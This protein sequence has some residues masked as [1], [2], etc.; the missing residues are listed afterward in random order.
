[1]SIEQSLNGTASGDP[2]DYYY[3]IPDYPET[4]NEGTVAGRVVDGLG[5]RYYWA[6]ENLAVTDL[7]FLHGKDSRSIAEVIDHVL[8]LSVMIVDSIA[9]RPNIRQDWSEIGVSEKR[10]K[11]LDYIRDAAEM[12]KSNKSGMDEYKVIFE[13]PKGTFE[14]PFWNILNGPISDAIYHVG[15]IV[16]LRRLSGNPINPGVRVFLGRTD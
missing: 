1:M 5:F 15:Q 10:T 14:Y 11:A 2:S 16:T 7:D 4:Y 12:L 13:R 3:Q 6:T 8:S 9:V